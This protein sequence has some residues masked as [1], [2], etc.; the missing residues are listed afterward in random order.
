MSPRT[1]PER[2]SVQLGW[3]LAALVVATAVPMT[4]VAAERM[5]LSEEFS[6]TT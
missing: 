5:V 6:S 2:C 1:F 3:S 4:A